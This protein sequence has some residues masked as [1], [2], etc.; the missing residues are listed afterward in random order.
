MSTLRINIVA[1]RIVFW[2]TII[3]GVMTVIFCERLKELR[4]AKKLTQ[5]QLAGRLDLTRAAVSSYENGV[6][7]PSYEL[8]TTIAG[9]FNVSTDYLLGQSSKQYLDTSG[10]TG[11]QIALLSGMIDEFKGRNIGNK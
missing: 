3:V 11:N 5:D 6:R 10:L 7:T 8:L 2:C 1:Q 9:I 4:T